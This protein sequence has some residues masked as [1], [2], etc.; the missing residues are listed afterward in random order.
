[1]GMERKERVMRMKIPNEKSKGVRV[2]LTLL[3]DNGVPLEKVIQFIGLKLKTIRSRRD[4]NRMMKDQL[5]IIM[6]CRSRMLSTVTKAHSSILQVPQVVS[7]I[8]QPIY[9]VLCP[10]SCGLS[11]LVRDYPF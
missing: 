8:I 1:M 2:Q 3:D 6:C 7:T 11:L 9:R 4:T 5:S 10:R